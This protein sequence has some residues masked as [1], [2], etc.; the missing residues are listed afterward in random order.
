MPSI[1]YIAIRFKVAVGGWTHVLCGCRIGQTTNWRIDQ[2]GY[3][4]YFFYIR[5]SL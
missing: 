2:L 5:T 1:R 4:C 3:D